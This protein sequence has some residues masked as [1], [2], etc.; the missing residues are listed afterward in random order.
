MTKNEIQN[1]I[2][3]LPIVSE[4]TIMLSGLGKP[5]HKE[6]IK[7]QIKWLLGRG[8]KV[9]HD[10]IF[11]PA[12][13]LILGLSEYLLST[14]DDAKDVNTNLENII[15]P[16]SSYLSKWIND[17]LK[18]SF[19]DDSLMGMALINILIY[20]K[21]SNFQFDELFISAIKKGTNNIAN[22]I[23]KA[24][25]DRKGSLIYHAEMDNEYIFADGAGMTAMF[26][27]AYSALNKDDISGNL[28]TL[29]LTNYI[30][31]GIDSHTS[32]PY[33]GYN[34]SS[35]EKLGIVG[36]GRAT[37][38]LMMGIAGY[39]AA[40]SGNRNTEIVGYINSLIDTI[41]EFQMNDGGFSW[42][43]SAKEG[44][45]DS[46][47]T[48][49]ISYSLCKILSTSNSNIILG[50][51]RYNKCTEIV[52]SSYDAIRSS[53][54][55]GKVLNSLAECIDFAQYPQRYGT[56]A[57]GQGAALAFLSQH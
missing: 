52:E 44:H 13:I 45:F 23:K 19:T 56:N 11:W 25:A 7:Q 14:L 33:H 10:S 42:D 54:S 39:F 34:L 41:Y 31:H 48:A 43:I 27:S 51:E 21:K 28:A 12:G 46:S 4:A 35:G 49:M 6:D 40:F 37:G 8:S 9:N 55:N 53:I 5:H 38:W 32:L 30:S 50:K 16:I 29:Q 20:S 2:T 26:L 1:E 17:G 15:N 36:W 3:L 22:F 18:V 57:W 24:P 47:G